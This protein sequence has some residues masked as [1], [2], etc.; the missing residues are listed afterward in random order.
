ML[1]NCSGCKGGH[2]WPFGSQCVHIQK[3]D[4]AEGKPYTDR[5]D[6]AYL[7]Y[8]ED[9]ISQHVVDQ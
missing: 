5:Q 8:I 9:Q 1:Q 2:V 6:P 4:M 7:T 3:R